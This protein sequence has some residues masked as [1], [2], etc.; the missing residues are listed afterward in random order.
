[1]TRLDR[2]LVPLAL[3]ALLLLSPGCGDDD[4]DD[5]DPVPTDAGSGGGTDAGPSPDAGMNPPIPELAAAAGLTSLLSAAEDAGL[6]DLLTN[7][8]PFTVFA[9]TND[10]FSR[11]TLT[12]TDTGLLANVLLHHVVNGVE[13]SGAVLSA[14]SFDTAANTTIAVDTMVTPVTIGGAPLS[15][16]LD[17][18]ASNGV[19]HIIDEVM[20]PPTIAEAA[21]A[22]D[23]L[24]VL[25]TVVEVASSTVQDALG[26][27]GPITVFAPVDEAFDGIELMDLSQQEVD[28]LLTYHVVAGQTLS[29]QLM[30]GATIT[31][32]NGGELEVSVD[33]NGAI[34]L[35]DA[36]GATVPVST[37]D[38]RLLNGT[39]HV[40]G[41][42][43]NPSPQ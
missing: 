5:D 35:I 18:G 15:N 1:M 42:V 19:V 14:E 11:F 12:S 10:A 2:L 27:P 6:V 7:G 20:V 3:P 28:A 16:S 43:L 24:S 41:G 32:L 25:A 21:A 33:P 40:I 8:G 38:M 39:V 31:T 26:G 9:P 37:P 4:D 17:N 13:E 22:L 34:S 30:N 36:S 29:T 23:E